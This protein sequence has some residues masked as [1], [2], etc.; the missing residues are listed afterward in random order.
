[1]KFL[2]QGAVDP[3]TIFKRDRDRDWDFSGET[4]GPVENITSKYD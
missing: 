2:K 1:L 3:V 4:A